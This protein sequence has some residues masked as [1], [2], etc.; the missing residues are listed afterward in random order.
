VVGYLEPLP[1]AEGDA[2]SGETEGA[3][4]LFI[5]AHPAVPGE[6]FVHR[7]RWGWFARLLFL[8]ALVFLF[9]EPE[10]VDGMW[11]GTLVISEAVVGVLIVLASP[12]RRRLATM[13]VAALAALGFVALEVYNDAAFGTLSLSGPPPKILACGQEYTRTAT[14]PIPIVPPVPLHRVGTTP[15]GRTLL[16][17]GRCGEHGS[18]WAFVSAGRG[19]VIAYLAEDYTGRP[20]PYSR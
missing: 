20:P 4:T 1:A 15:S 14:R 9:F 5:A 17:N 12:G 13:V 7:S 19:L 2:V 16:G 10:R 8:A 11:W 6:L 18:V 3:P